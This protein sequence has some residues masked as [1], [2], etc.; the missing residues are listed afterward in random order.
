MS[1]K[2]IGVARFGF[3][4]QSF[5]KMTKVAMPYDL[6]HIAKNNGGRWNAEEKSWFV[7]SNAL[8]KVIEQIKEYKQQQEDADQDTDASGMMDDDWRGD[9]DVPF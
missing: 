2:K 7:P 5:D 1:L 3:V 6:R 4:N 9:E 8:K